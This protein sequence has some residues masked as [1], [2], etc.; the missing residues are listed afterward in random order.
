MGNRCCRCPCCLSSL[1]QHGLLWPRTSLSA[2]LLFIPATQ[3]S[4][5]HTPPPTTTVNTPPPEQVRS[6]EETFEEDGQ[7]QTRWKV[8]GGICEGFQTADAGAAYLRSMWDDAVHDYSQAPE[9]CW[10]RDK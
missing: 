3:L 8:T 1:R 6:C 7:N 9:G 4:N 10:H 2:W 5:T